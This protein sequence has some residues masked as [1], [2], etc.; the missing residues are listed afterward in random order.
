[1][2]AS[3][4]VTIPEILPA[5]ILKDLVAF[6]YMVFPLFLKRDERLPFEKAFQ[7]VENLDIS[8]LHVFPYSENGNH[9]SR[10]F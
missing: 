6:P 2:P 3:S 4:H 7:F 9:G 1:M 10:S 5:F 8:E